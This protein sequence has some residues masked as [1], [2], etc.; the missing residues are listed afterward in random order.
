MTFIDFAT[1]EHDTTISFDSVKNLQN[2]KKAQSNW[3]ERKYLVK[4]TYNAEKFQVANKI[5]IFFR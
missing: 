2:T 4:G 3:K 5:P 1:P